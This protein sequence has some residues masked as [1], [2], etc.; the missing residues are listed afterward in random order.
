[1]A[2]AKWFPTLDLKSGKCEVDIHPDDTEK[3]H[4]P[5]GRGC[6]SSQS[7]PLASAM[8]RRH[9]I[10]RYARFM[11]CV[12]GH[13]DRDWPHIPRAPAQLVEDIPMVPRSPSEAKS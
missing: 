11:C 13:R 7:C 12:F 1:M 5:Q 8:L 4:S 6:G 2:G 3:P 10:G 9:L